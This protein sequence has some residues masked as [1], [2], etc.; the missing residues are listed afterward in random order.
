MK[1]DDKWIADSDVITQT[2]EEKF[3]EPPLLTPPEKASMYVYVLYPP[4]VQFLTF[5]AHWWLVIDM[6]SGSK[7]F[8][9]YIGFL[10]SKDPNDGKEEALLNELSA[11]NDYIKENVSFSRILYRIETLLFVS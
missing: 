6:C 9:T 11:F 3:P 5:I 4:F 8:S 1:L 7:I 10:K 2:V